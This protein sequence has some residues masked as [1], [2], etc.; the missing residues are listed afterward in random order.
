MQE[1]PIETTA[2]TLQVAGVAGI[3]LQIETIVPVFL[4]YCSG[5]SLFGIDF[6]MKACIV[7]TN[8]CKTEMIGP[9]S[10]TGESR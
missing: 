9:S 4:P 7:I 1:T 10:K 5:I 2:F 6:P 8:G 3:L